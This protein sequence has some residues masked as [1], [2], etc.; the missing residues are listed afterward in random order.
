MKKPTNLKKLAGAISAVAMSSVLLSGCGGDSSSSS[1]DVAL[2]IA[3]AQQDS[4]KTIKMYGGNGGKDGGTG[5]DGDY[6]QLQ[7]DVGGKN[8]VTPKGSVDASFQ[9]TALSSLPVELGDNPLIVDED[10]VAAAVSVPG[11]KPAVGTVYIRADGTRYLAISDGNTAAFSSNEHVTGIQINAGKT[12]SVAPNNGSEANFNLDHDLI[13]KGTLASEDF[14]AN[15]RATLDL[16]VGGS[17]LI[18]PSGAVET[19]GRQDGQNGGDIDIDASYAAI[20]HGTYRSYGADSAA[21][22]GG[23]AGWTWLYGSYR[24]ENTGNVYAYGGDAPQ[25]AAGDG[26]W[27]G[28]ESGWGELNVRGQFHGY[29][30]EGESGG[31]ANG[32]YAYAEMGDTN[33][34]GKIWV[35]GGDATNGDAGDTNS[36]MDFY[37]YGGGI[38]LNA[39]IRA[40]GGDSVA[41]GDG[42]DGADLYLFNEEGAI[43]E[44]TPHDGIFVAGNI[45]IAGGNAGEDSSYDGGD[46]GYIYAEAAEDDSLADSQPIQFHGF[47]KIDASGGDGQYGGDAAD[48][49][50]YSYEG[51]NDPRYEYVAGEGNLLNVS[52]DFSG[53]DALADATGN[54]DGGRSAGDFYL[55]TDYYYA[56][57]FLDR[58]MNVVTGLIDLSGGQNNNSTS[59]SSGA[60]N[61]NAWLWAYNG[62]QLAAI[63]A[64]GGDDVASDGGTDGYGGDAD[65]SVY[66]YSEL[67]ASKFGRL[68]RSGGDGEYRGGDGGFVDGEAPSYTGGK[69]DI[70]GGNADPALAGSV[71]GDVDSIWLYSPK[72]FNAVNVGPIVAN[73]G[74]GETEGSS[75]NYVQLGDVCYGTDC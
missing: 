62:Q 43:Y 44:Y 7:N 24:A 54:G 45:N 4:G 12:L 64:S 69:I 53:G 36:S 9:A 31:D 10:I 71:G 60:S 61:G 70:S 42:G 74:A 66:F 40:Y 20:N 38:Y 50:V 16:N 41:G 19:Y 30:G 25:G 37:S 3:L 55:E 17:M 75:D 33:V 72:G 39:D 52:L 34:S 48:L 5:G 26:E 63:D 29:G 73:P 57:M 15:Q 58:G 28:F 8:V 23:D 59:N 47:G 22:D 49:Y 46:G 27:I 6:F 21:G 51:W 11:S 35:Y 13:I 32:F 67:G 14:D 18:Y 1:D 56:S 68:D 65:G 2:A